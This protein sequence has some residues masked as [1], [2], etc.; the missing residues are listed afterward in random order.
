[1]N[2]TELKEATEL[3]K[4]NGEGT[5]YLPEFTKNILNRM[6]IGSPVYIAG[7]QGSGKTEFVELI[8][9]E[10]GKKLHT[11]DFSS[12]V[13]ESNIVGR[14]LVK[15][16]ET[17]FSYG[18]LAQAMLNGDHILFDEIDYAEPEHLSI[19]N[20]V[21]TGRGL[22]VTQNESEVIYPKEG[23]RIFA[24]GNTKGRG[25]EDQI[26]AGTNVLNI[27][28][29]DRFSVFEMGYTSKEKNIMETYIDDKKLVKMLSDLFKI[30]RGASENQ[31]L[32]NASFSTRRIIQ[33]C[34]ALQMGESLAE[35]LDVEIISRF[36]KDETTVL[37]EY[38]DDVFDKDFYLNG[39][40]LGDAHME[41][42][43][44]ITN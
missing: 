20:S 5:F 14:L 10:V 3:Q 4:E 35:A 16:G 41:K 42:S 12:G 1:M 33:I 44:D 17:K 43:A 29:L 34:K 24:T 2:L 28:F 25:D 7:P 18:L 30:F 32:I 11:I 21:L 31:D 19:M 36:E 27:A 40:K 37:Y 39:W 23:F 26:F 6:K 22:V 15:N 38:I 8:S 9:R 13:T